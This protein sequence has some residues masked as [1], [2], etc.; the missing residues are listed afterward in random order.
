MR[1]T[2]LIL[3][4]SLAAASALAQSSMSKP[5]RIVIAAATV[6][7]G[8]GGVLHDTHIVVEG[9]KIVALD[10]QASPVDYDLRRLT[11]LPG[12]V[13]AHVHITWFFGRDG[14]LAPPSAPADESAYAAASKRMGH[15]DGRL[16]HRAKRG[17]AGR[18]PPA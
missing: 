5:K 12:W 11:V 16:H 3:C 2:E 7:D 6:L 17:L 8:R 15:T 1:S 13:D 4:L 14:K 10:P 9:S 18:C